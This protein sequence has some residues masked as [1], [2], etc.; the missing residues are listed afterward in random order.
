M[1][2]LSKKWILGISLFV[3]ISSLFLSACS[4]S[5]ST[6]TVAGDSGAKVMPT[7]S[8]PIVIDPLNRETRIAAKVNGSTFT[9]PTWHAIVY[10]SGKAAGASVFQAYASPQFFYD[11]MKYF[12]GT[13]GDN[14]PMENYSSTYVKG[15]DID[16]YVTWNGAPKTYTLAEV[17]KDP[18]G[19]NGKDIK[20]KFG[21]NQDRI[22]SGGTGCITC[23]YS[24]PMGVSSNSAYNGDDFARQKTAGQ[25]G[26]LANKDVLPADGT[27]VVLIFK[28]K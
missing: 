27:P 13:P 26:F 9:S 19:V 5:V 8:N 28:V 23:L 1:K 10:T 22:E 24:C 7:E 20:I 4:E 17:L 16:I 3:I 14:M 6:K 11:A 12:G 15:S 25:A 2:S 21:G 18:D